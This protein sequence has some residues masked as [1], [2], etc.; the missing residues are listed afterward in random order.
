[1]IQHLRLSRHLYDVYHLTQNPVAERAIHDKALYET[2]VSHRQ[3]FSK[4]SGINY[5]DHNPKQLDPIPLPEVQDAWKE[6]YKK[7]LEEMIYEEN[8]PTFEMLI[9]TLKILKEKLA[10]VEWE[11][12]LEFPISNL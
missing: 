12:S 2:I 4:V 1:V 6:D 10:H 11:F 5:N 7:M 8:P 9:E 3:K